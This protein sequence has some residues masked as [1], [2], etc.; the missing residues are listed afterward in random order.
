MI[1]PN[2]SHTRP[3][4]L[5]SPAFPE[6]ANAGAGATLA[7]GVAFQFRYNLFSNSF[8]CPLEKPSRK[9]VFEQSFQIILPHIFCGARCLQEVFKRAFSVFVIGADQRFKNP[10]SQIRF[11]AV[12]V[13]T[14]PA[15]N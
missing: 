14:T 6:I 7:L 8:V 11:R 13:K 1:K 3:L 15:P 12:S 5:V 10:S 9:T 4:P 2:T